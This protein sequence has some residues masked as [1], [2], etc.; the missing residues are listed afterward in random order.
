V[1]K[2]KPK[3][4]PK[5]PTLPTISFPGPAGLIMDERRARLVKMLSKKT[6]V[7]VNVAQLVADLENVDALKT[8][9][10]GWVKDAETMGVELRPAT[11]AEF[12][13]E[14]LAAKKVLERMRDGLSALQKFFEPLPPDIRTSLG[15]AALSAAH[16]DGQAPDESVLA[17]LEFLVG[18][19]RN[20]VAELSASLPPSD[21]ALQRKAKIAAVAAIFHHHNVNIGVGT[22]SPFVTVCREFGVPRSTLM[23][24]LPEIKDHLV[25]HVE[26]LYRGPR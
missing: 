24:Y 20:L 3:A 21:A 26:A 17:L 6:R 5:E 7:G 4:A 18:S 13:P 10:P 16:R 14:Q 19:A 8:N 23:T 12:S 25:Q 2:P 15:Q 1:T 22:S 9:R 11:V